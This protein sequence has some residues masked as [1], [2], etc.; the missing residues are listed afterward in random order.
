MAKLTYDGVYEG[1]AVLVHRLLT[2]EAFLHACL[3]EARA[4][5]RDVRVQRSADTVLVQMRGTVTVGGVPAAAQS[6]VGSSVVIDQ[7][8]AWRRA[9][10]STWRATTLTEVHAMRKGEAIGE[11]S[12]EPMGERSQFH[13]RADVTVDVPFLGGKL[14][15]MALGYIRQGLDQQ[16]RLANRW[17][18]DGYRPAGDPQP[19]VAP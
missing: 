11:A 9:A 2:D 19:P 18:A 8:L 10:D 17:L 4:T 3:D 7:T 13:V 1:D 12:L 6:M 14:A 5:E 16:T 15:E